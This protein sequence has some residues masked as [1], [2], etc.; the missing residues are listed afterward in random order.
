[1]T[2]LWLALL[3]AFISMPVWSNNDAT[4][5]RMLNITSEL[6]CL[7]CQNET[8]AE[9]RSDFSNDIRALISRQIEAGK[10]D[11]EIEAFLVSRYGDFILYRPPLKSSTLLLWFGPLLLFIFGFFALAMALHRRKRRSVATSLSREEQQR[12]DALLQTAP[13]PGN[14]L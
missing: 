8:V 7:V 5:D 14:S 3:C 12:A 11:T 9:S 4:K 2:R 1:M 10:S 6:R 13:H